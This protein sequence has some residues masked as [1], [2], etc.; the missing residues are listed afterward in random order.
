VVGGDGVANLLEDRGLTGARGRDDQ[1]AGPFADGRHEIDDAGLEAIGRGLQLKLVDRIDGGEI[2][3]AHG[4]QIVLVGLAIDFDH[5]A[6]L[7]IGIER[8]H[9][10]HLGGA[11]IGKTYI[12]VA[13]KQGVNHCF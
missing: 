12:N 13:C 9:E 3:K 1:T 6:H 8:R 2:L 11:G 10:V 7:R 4:V 5:L